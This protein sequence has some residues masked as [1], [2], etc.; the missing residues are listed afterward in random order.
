[1]A[2]GSAAV[3]ARRKFSGL[4][5]DASDGV[6]KAFK[7]ATTKPTSTIDFAEAGLAYAD[8]RV[9][10]LTAS[11]LTVGDVSATE[12]GYLDGVSSAIQTQL[13]SKAP[14][15]NPTFTGLVTT[16][17]IK[18]TTGAGAGKVLTSDADGDATWETASGGGLTWSAVVNNATMVVDT[19]TIA[20][21]GSLLEL[22]LPTT[23]A[24]G[25]VLR[26]A[27]MNAG[28]WKVIQGANQYIKMGSVAS[29]VGATGYISSTLTY[30]CVE[31]VCIEADK[32]WVVVSSMGTI[33][34]A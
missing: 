2:T 13:D 32:G 11:S 8:V 1:V 6:I 29:T 24:V 4:A 20:N 25:K 26:I 17:A 22:T 12:I 31:M 3:S 30:D 27:G 18:V 9:G 5:R 16:P 7:D 33:T 10:A 19:G 34:I 21:K 28:L 23:S 14:I 15:A